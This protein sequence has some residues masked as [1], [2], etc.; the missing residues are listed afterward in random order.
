[1]DLLIQGTDPVNSI[2]LKAGWNLVGYP[3]LTAQSSQNAMSGMPE[4][5]CIYGYNGDK[6][7][8]YIVDGPDFLN[9]LDTLEPGYGYYIFVEEDLV[10]TV[11]P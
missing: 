7:L 1:M 4:G 10:W 11:L 9:D 5:T 8:N 6:W 2:N 3:S